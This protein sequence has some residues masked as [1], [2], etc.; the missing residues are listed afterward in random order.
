MLQIDVSLAGMAVHIT[1]SFANNTTDEGTVQLQL[2]Y[3]TVET[4]SIQ[5]HTFTVCVKIVCLTM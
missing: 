5:W 4:I 2:Y 1:S 3:D